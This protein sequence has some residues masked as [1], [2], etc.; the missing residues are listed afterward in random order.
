MDWFHAIRWANTVSNPIVCTDGQLKGATEDD[1]CRG[2][3]LSTWD[4][5]SWLRAEESSEGEEPDDVLQVCFDIPV[6][7]A[8]LRDALDS[9]AITGIQYL[10][11]KVFDA[12]GIELE[13][14]AIANL[15]NV[16]DVLDLKRSDYEVFGPD[17]PDRMGKIRDLRKAVIR[18]DAVEG[19]DIVRPR[20]FPFIILASRKFRN[21]FTEGKFTGFKFKKVHSLATSE[22][23]R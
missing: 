22:E 21:V 20:E 7:S 16:L 11:I 17:R 13:G 10:P 8:R 23:R 12:R 3:D 2:T 19:C 18:M 6:F 1:L 9:S 14:F 5:T 15:L 4:P